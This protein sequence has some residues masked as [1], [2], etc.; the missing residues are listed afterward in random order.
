MNSNKTYFIAEAGVNHNGDKTMAMKLIEEAAMAGA[1]A[2][3]F[4]TFNAKKIISKTL[5]KANYQKKS[6]K[7]ISSQYEMLKKLELPK[8][9]YKDLISNA[10][11]MKIDFISTPFD[12]ESLNFLYSLRVPFFKIPSGEINNLPFL[13]KIANLRKN[14]ILSTGMSN[15]SDIELA[16]AVLNHGFSSR[17]QPKDLDEV[18]AL[19]SKL[20]INK[21]RKKV[22]ILHC[23]SN[24]PAKDNEVNLNAI[25]TLKK[26]FKIPVGF[27][28]HSLGIHL[29]IAAIA[30]GAVIIEKHLTLDK[31][32]E[33]P[34]HSSSLEPLELKKLVENIRSLENALGDGIKKTQKNEWEVRGKVRK[35]IVASRKI[36][37]GEKFSSKNLKIIR[38]ETGLYPENYWNLLGTISDKNYSENDSIDK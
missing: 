17:T 8:S 7:D 36:K 18:W 27:S 29:P 12:Y 24:Y 25:K 4:Q 2:I 9:F 14:V 26:A 16:L 28:D 34:D 1:N 30:L 13:W 23:L 33:G 31:N 21:F 22:S 32:L 15:L 6:S 38:S 5:D 20:D 37:K 10:K 11:K 19:W 35:K 3:K